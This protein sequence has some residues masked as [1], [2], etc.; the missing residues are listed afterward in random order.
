MPLGHQIP[1]CL[2]FLYSFILITSTFKLTSFLFKWPHTK[3]DMGKNNR[4]QWVKGKEK[5]RNEDTKQV[6]NEEWIWEVM[7]K[8]DQ[9]NVPNS[10]RI[11]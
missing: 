5:K 4:T 6:W 7:D 2:K 3:E 9:K 11:N 10:P 8:Y 1:S